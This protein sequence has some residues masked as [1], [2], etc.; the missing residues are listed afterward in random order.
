MI[1]DTMI[2]RIDLENEIDYNDKQIL[3]LTEIR[4][5]SFNAGYGLEFQEGINTAIRSIEKCS[6]NIRC[7]IQDKYNVD[8]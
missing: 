8:M 3:E 1:S 5:K 2:K 7:E 6:L 4:D